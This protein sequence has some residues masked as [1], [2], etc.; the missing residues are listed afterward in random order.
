MQRKATGCH[1]HNNHNHSSNNNHHEFNGQDI[2]HITLDP[3]MTIQDLVNMYSKTGYNGRQLGEAAK[4]YD[5]YRYIA[6]PTADLGLSE[7]FIYLGFTKDGNPKFGQVLSSDFGTT[8]IQKRIGRFDGRNLSVMGGMFT[9][10]IDDMR[11][12]AYQ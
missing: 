9:K 1:R 4:L 7:E 6:I 5:G 8:K 11:E 12:A 3:K 2:P 10:L